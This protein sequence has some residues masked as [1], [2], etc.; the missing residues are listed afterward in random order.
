MLEPN[1]GNKAG[2]QLCSW[3]SGVLHYARAQW[4]F[5]MGELSLTIIFCAGATCQSIKMPHRTHPSWLQNFTGSRR[6]QNPSHNKLPF[7]LRCSSLLS[8]SQGMPSAARKGLPSSLL[9]LH[10]RKMV[11]ETLL[12]KLPIAR[13][14]SAIQFG[15]PAALMPVRWCRG[16]LLL[17]FDLNPPP[18]QHK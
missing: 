10:T 9:H 3:K 17:T 1:L 2:T 6:C 12:F 5:W 15:D 7:L 13:A 18:C 4:A 14:V 16:L 11:S 8:Y